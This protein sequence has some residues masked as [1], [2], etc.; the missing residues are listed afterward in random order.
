[1]LGTVAW[2][3]RRPSTKYLRNHREPHTVV[4]V[5][6]ERRFWWGY[7]FRKQDRFGSAL[8]MNGRCMVIDACGRFEQGYFTVS[9]A[10]K[11]G[12]SFMGG[13]KVF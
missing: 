9:C 2:T 13:M 1:M 8:L 4:N 5:K 11:Y 12:V 6:H 10:S 7:L 3:G